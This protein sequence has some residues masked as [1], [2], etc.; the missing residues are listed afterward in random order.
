VPIVTSFGHTSPDA[1][2]AATDLGFAKPATCRAAGTCS[3]SCWCLP[4]SCM[5][6]RRR[7]DWPVRSRTGGD[8]DLAGAVGPHRLCRTH[9]AAHADRDAGLVL[10]TFTY[11]TLA[12]KS[13][14]AEVILVPLLDFLQSVP[15]LGFSITIVF[16]LQ[17]TPGRVAG[18]ELAAIS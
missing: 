9:R 8:A 3:P 6:R 16:F 13:R 1:H 5:S 11:A 4:S 15:I 12:A 14:R 10:F 17:L 2:R 7:T 18:A